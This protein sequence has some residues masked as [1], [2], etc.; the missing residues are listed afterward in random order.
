MA[1]FTSVICRLRL[2]V[3]ADIQPSTAPKV[4]LTLKGS[5]ETKPRA[6]FNSKFLICVV[7]Q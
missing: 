6:N 4:W 3:L 5:R 2:F 1:R 7:E